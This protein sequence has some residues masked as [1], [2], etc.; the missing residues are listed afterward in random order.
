MKTF[1][2]EEIINKQPLGSIERLFVIFCYRNNESSN[3]SYRCIN[4]R[5]KKMDLETRKKT[6][7]KLILLFSFESYIRNIINC[8]HY[9]EN[10][11][12]KLK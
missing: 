4:K 9:F 3:A 6:C 1:K 12:L 11:F 7:K 2:I 5:L 8:K 10:N